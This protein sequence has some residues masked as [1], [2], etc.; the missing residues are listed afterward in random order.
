MEISTKGMN[1]MKKIILIGSNEHARMVIDNIEQQGKYEIFGIVTDKREIIG[2]KL[3]GYELICHD[4][5][6]PILI[7]ENKD[8][9][10]YF[11]GIG[12]MKVREKLY[13]KLDM[14]IESVNIIH[15]TSIISKHSRIG[16][17]NIFEA[18]TKIA[19]D[20]IVGN[21]CILNSFTS[22]NHDQKVGN[23]VL[24]GCNVSLAGKTIGNNTI[25]ADG[26]S[27]AFKKSVGSQCIIGDGS[28]VTRDI[29]DFTI[30]YGNPAREVMKND[31]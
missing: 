13:K 14:T 4:N 15:P 5:E 16:K 10:G 21:H 12:N 3:K 25:I 27:I 29:P 18:Y 20:V 30:A 17:G 8:I 24:I 11:L 19:N 28:V 6:V 9:V 31:W 7:K 22:I 26:A 23:N 1:G 2:T